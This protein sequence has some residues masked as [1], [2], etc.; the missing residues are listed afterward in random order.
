MQ[1][2][3]VIALIAGVLLIVGP[4]C[5]I[6]SV[7]I[8]G[9][10]TYFKNGQGDGTIVVVMGV[11]TI[12]LAIM[13]KYL[14]L[15]LTGVPSIGLAVYTFLQ[16]RQKIGELSDKL[17]DGL[18]DNPFKDLAEYAAQSVQIKWGLAVVV[19]GG[20]L[21]VVAACMPDEAEDNSVA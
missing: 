16:L 8:V 4:F 13:Q 3:Q 14:L 1:A 9:D 12:G 19:V 11:V 2:R 6:V 17:S 10:I 18:K 5:P 7:P 21:A 15:W 20:L